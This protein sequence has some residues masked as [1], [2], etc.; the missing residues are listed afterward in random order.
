MQNDFATHNRIPPPF[1][2]LANKTLY[3]VNNKNN[4]RTT[5]TPGETLVNKTNKI[6]YNWHAQ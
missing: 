2:M 4:M 6:Q 3:I 5:Q 1:I